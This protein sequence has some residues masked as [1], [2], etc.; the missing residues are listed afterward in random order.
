MIDVVLP[1][2]RTRNGITMPLD[3]HIRLKRHNMPLSLF[4]A[5]HGVTLPVSKE[6]LSKDAL[7]AIE[8][9]IYMDETVFLGKSG[10]WFT[11][12]NNKFGAERVALKRVILLPYMVWPQDY[13]VSITRYQDGRH[14]YATIDNVDL[15]DRHKTWSQAMTAALLTKIKEEA[16]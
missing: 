7:K 5:K 10:E 15:P 8:T 14:Y 11:A 13:E 1:V 2:T 3:W 6:I 12:S 16:R 9:A 4:F